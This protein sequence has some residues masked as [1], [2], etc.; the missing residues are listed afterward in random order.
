MPP[1]RTWPPVNAEDTHDLLIPL[2]EVKL[3]GRKQ[4]LD[5]H[6]VPLD[7][8]GD[9][10]ALPSGPISRTSGIS[11]WSMPFGNSMQTLCP[12]SKPGR[13]GGVSLSTR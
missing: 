11:P 1:L 5:D 10:V 13:Q 4:P 3:S 12:S 2:A 6:V 9:E 8:V 7:P